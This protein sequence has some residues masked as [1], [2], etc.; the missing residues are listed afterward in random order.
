MEKALGDLCITVDKNGFTDHDNVVIHSYHFKVLVK[1]E[2]AFDSLLKV[3]L[4]Q[5]T[6]RFLRIQIFIISAKRKWY[7]TIPIS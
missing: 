6:E 2:K 1:F 5:T 4:N 3:K 7:E